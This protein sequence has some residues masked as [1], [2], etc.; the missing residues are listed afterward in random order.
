MVS[1]M[2]VTHS[3]FETTFG[4]AALAHL[5]L[6]CVFSTS[7]KDTSTERL[8]RGG[9]TNYRSRQAETVLNVDAWFDLEQSIQLSDFCCFCCCT[10]TCVEVT[11][12]THQDMSPSSPAVSMQQRLSMRTLIGIVAMDSQPI[13]G[14]IVVHLVC[15]FGFVDLTLLVLSSFSQY[16]TKGKPAEE[17]GKVNRNGQSV[18]NI[19][20]DH[21][22]S[23]VDIRWMTIVSTN[24]LRASW[25]GK[26]LLL[27]LSRPLMTLCRWENPQGKNK[28]RALI[29]Q[30]MKSPCLS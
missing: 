3:T 2:G 11:R 4:I 7:T 15:V 5:L 20:L 27:Y 14:S 30:H 28:T 22:D 25:Y 21:S 9:N 19:V 23:T 6:S 18:R 16:Y 8:W 17:L 10:D 29:K 1:H 26:A 13:M 12:E 24:G